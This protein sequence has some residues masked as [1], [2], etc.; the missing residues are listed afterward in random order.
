MPSKKGKTK[1]KM[2]NWNLFVMKIKS[3]NPEKSLKDCL[4]LA[5]KM[6]KQ[7]VEMAKYIGNK[8]DKAIRKINKSMKKTMKKTIKKSM[9]KIIKKVK[10]RPKKTIKK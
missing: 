5:S 8:T 1:K 9:K 4:K 7:G 10:K 2:S 3:E 6:K